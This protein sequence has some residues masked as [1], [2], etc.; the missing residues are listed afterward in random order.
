MPE[1]ADILAL[2][3]HIDHIAGENRDDPRIEATV[4]RLLPGTAGYQQGWFSQVERFLQTVSGRDS[5]PLPNYQT[6]V[7]S[8][9][10]SR[11]PPEDWQIPQQAKARYAATVLAEL[12]LAVSNGGLRPFDDDPVLVDLARV[13]AVGTEQDEAG[14]DFLGLIQA[15]PPSHSGWH[16]FMARAQQE[17]LVTPEEAAL[18]P[19]ARGKIRAFGDEFCTQLDT[20]Y[21]DPTLDM[22]AINKVIDP[23]N[24]PGCC[25]YWKTVKEVLTPANEAGWTRIYEVVQVKSSVADVTLTTPLIFRNASVGDGIVVNYD[26]DTD[27]NGTQTDDFVY[28]DNGYI[29]ATPINAGQNP[30]GVRVHTRK[31]ARIQ[32]LGVAAL[33]MYAYAMGW[34]TAGE[35]LIL[36]CAKNPPNKA[37]GFKASPKATKATPTLP[38]TVPPIPK[39]GVK[40]RQQ[41]VGKVVD[42]LT[43]VIDER[44]AK[45]GEL[46][47]RWFD[48]DL[49]PTNVTVAGAEAGFAAARTHTK[50]HTAATQ[51]TPAPETNPKT[52]A[53]KEKQKALNKKAVAKKVPPKKVPPKKVPAKK[54]PVKGKG[55]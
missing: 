40:E 52:N 39:L 7:Q 14:F 49:L 45:T 1:I 29:W 15:E 18:H 48:G 30:S 6:A 4:H 46:V 26:L 9:G 51:T 38:P 34:S 37:V 16:R 27:R 10:E 31:V 28:V 3:G 8:L 44:S 35:N 21:E 53:V 22:Y 33:A 25:P 41:F 55:K 13:L 19:P 20:P 11:I 36:G 42:A 12:Q 47:Q 24:W 50:L 2:F 32:G 5:S 43:N 23:R 17:G 54:K